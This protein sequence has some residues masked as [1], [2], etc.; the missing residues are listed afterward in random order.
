MLL[1]TK[2]NPTGERSMHCRSNMLNL[3]LELFDGVLDD[4]RDGRPSALSRRQLDGEHSKERAA[5]PLR[6]SERRHDAL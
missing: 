2:A 6:F 4:A 1:A 5:G 3:R